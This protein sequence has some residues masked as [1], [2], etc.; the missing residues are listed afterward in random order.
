LDRNELDCNT[1][2]RSQKSLAVN[3]PHRG[4]QGP[5]LRL[6][7]STCIKVE[8]EGERSAR[9]RGG[10]AAQGVQDQDGSSL[11]LPQLPPD[12]AQKQP[13]WNGDGGLVSLV[14]PFAE[15]RAEG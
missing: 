8:G 14:Q 5:L 3:T 9:K 13:C 10:F 4:S 11:G 7:G 12:H 15:H 6:I 2:S 1:V